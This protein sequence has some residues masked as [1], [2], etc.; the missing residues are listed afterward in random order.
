MLNLKDW[1]SSSKHCVIEE[2]SEVGKVRDDLSG[3]C[4]VVSL[5][6]NGSMVLHQLGCVAQFSLSQVILVFCF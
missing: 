1:A 2:G 5:L 3:C 6:R 4:G